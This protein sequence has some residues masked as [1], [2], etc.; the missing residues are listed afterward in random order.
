M[1]VPADIWTVVKAQDGNAVLIRPTGSDSVVPIF[2]D[3]S[4]AHS[5]VM[6]LGDVNAARPLTHDLFVSVLSRLDAEVN[7]IEITAI[8]DSI[9]Y[10]RLILLQ[11][12]EEM[13]ID[14]RPSDCVA[15]A[16]RVKCPIF[17]D[18]E[19]VSHAGMPAS[20]VS[21]VDD[22][23]RSR[24]RKR[25]GGRSEENSLLADLQKELD[26]AVQDEDYEQAA[27]IRDRINEL[28]KD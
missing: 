20:S 2:V 1:L 12:D 25:Q 14:A 21:G 3:P 17:I 5:I 18:E 26:A 7:R 28:Q 4:I 15:L 6:G 24:Q 27:K 10:A 16:V 9:F 19:V 13:V 23:D 22:G 8:N 11:E